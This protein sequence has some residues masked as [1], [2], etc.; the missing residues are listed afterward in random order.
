M[1]EHADRH[2]AVE[3][4]FEV[5]VVAQLEI[6][7]LGKSHGA[8]AL[9]GDLELL[10]AQG[11]AGDVDM[12]RLGKVERQA[13]PTGPDIEDPH[14]VVEI[15]L[16][17][18]MPLLRLLGGFE[19]HTVMLEIGAGILAVAV[20][21]EIVERAV[22]VVVMRHIA[23]GAANGVEVLDAR[24]DKAQAIEEAKPAR[25]ALPGD[26]GQQKLEKVVD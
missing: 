22:D 2:D 23:L 3:L 4:A 17:R 12:G 10:F 7:S 13:P 8:G 25:P 21:E 16:C 5:A 26:V 18:K 19:R 14:A 6:D 1:L 24:R 11:D 15:E 20:E 9:P